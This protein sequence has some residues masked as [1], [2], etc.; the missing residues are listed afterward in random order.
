[1]LTARA[2]TIATV[3]SETADSHI[4]S[5]RVRVVTGTTSVGLNAVA[6]LNARNR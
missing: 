3:A 2:A 4:I 6:V 5:S 1:M